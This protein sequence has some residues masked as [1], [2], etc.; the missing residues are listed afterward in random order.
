MV[1][2]ASLKDPWMRDYHNLVLP[3]GH[4]SVQ[5]SNSLANH[6]LE[7]WSEFMRPNINFSRRIPSTEWS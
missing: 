2:A 5:A 7:G 6:H 4:S 3:W 1:N